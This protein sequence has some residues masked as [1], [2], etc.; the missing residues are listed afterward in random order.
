MGNIE[1]RSIE[2]QVK[3]ETGIQ[4]VDGERSAYIAPEDLNKGPV[5]CPELGNILVAL[6]PIEVP[7]GGTRWS[8]DLSDL[9][10]TLLAG[11]RGKTERRISMNRGTGEGSAMYGPGRVINARLER[12]DSQVGRQNV[13][14]GNNGNHWIGRWMS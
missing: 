13:L 14:G 7:K 10:G 3:I 4:L 12:R 8:V 6:K 2:P 5:R 11:S 1:A 9:G